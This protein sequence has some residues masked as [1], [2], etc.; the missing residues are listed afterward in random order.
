MARTE[1][2]ASHINP[3]FLKRL[4]VAGASLRSIAVL[5]ILGGVFALVFM[6]LWSGQLGLAVLNIAHVS[7][8]V[9]GA[10]GFAIGIGLLNYSEAARGA[11]SMWFLAWGILQLVVGFT[12]AW[13]GN[14]LIGIFCMVGGSIMVVFADLL[15]LPAEVFVCAYVAGDLSAPMVEEGILKGQHDTSHPAMAAFVATSQSRATDT[16]PKASP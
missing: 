5:S 16:P 4:E 6:V 9:G 13:Q 7:F 14:L 3:A 12:A 8:L 2:A 10:I 11:G 1:R 15:H